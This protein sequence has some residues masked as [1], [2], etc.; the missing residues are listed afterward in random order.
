MSFR[1]WNRRQ[2]SSKTGGQD[3]RQWLLWGGTKRS[4]DRRGPGLEEVAGT[5]TK[6]CCLPFRVV[7]DEEAETI[8]LRF[9]FYSL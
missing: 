5:G 1:E 7:C 8:P 3:W 9:A 4:I 2:V 6:V